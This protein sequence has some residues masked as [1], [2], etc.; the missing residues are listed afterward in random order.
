MPSGGG[1]AL[2]AGP[3]RERTYCLNDS[4]TTCS[5][6]R[7]VSRKGGYIE[8]VCTPSSRRISLSFRLKCFGTLMEYPAVLTRRS[9]LF[10]ISLMN[11]ALVLKSI[12]N[13]VIIRNSSASRGELNDLSCFVDIVSKFSDVLLA[14]HAHRFFLQ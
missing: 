14:G 7:T 12:G 9:G 11:V 10:V 2:P 6:R 13:E 8:S 1:Y 5:N 3:I 4:S